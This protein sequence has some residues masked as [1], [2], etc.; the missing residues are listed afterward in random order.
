MMMLQE[1]YDFC[2]LVL[3]FKDQTILPDELV[4]LET[5]LSG[6]PEALDLYDR[7]VELYSG[8]YQSHGFPAS[9]DG[10]AVLNSDFW[11]C[12]ANEEITAPS[13]VI[14][15]PKQPSAPA[16]IRKVVYQ[17]PVRQVSKWSIFTL[18][19]SSAA[20]LLLSLFVRFAPAPDGREVATLTDSMN[21]R[22]SGG[23]ET[24]K[25]GVRL[26]AKS[27]SL[28][29][30]EGIAKLTFDNGSTVVVEGPA[31]F[32]ILAEDR[33]RVKYG[34][35]YTIVPRAVLGFSVITPN[36][37]II[38][39]GTEFG[40]IA[41]FDGSTE[42]HVIKGET[43]L[44]TGQ[45]E[46]KTSLLVKQGAAKQIYGESALVSDIVPNGRLFIQNLNSEANLIWRGGPLDLA[47]IVGGGNGFG[48]GKINGGFNPLKDTFEIFSEIVNPTLGPKKY[49]PVAGNPM[50]DGIFVPNGA[51]GP[52]QVSTQGHMFEK[53]P[54]TNGRFW[55]G[56]F[57]GAWHGAK[58]SNITRHSLRL[59]GKTYGTVQNASIYI[60]ANQGITFDLKAIRKSVGELNVTGFSARAG[61]SES[62]LDYPKLIIRNAAGQ[63]TSPLASF[64]VL[65]DGQV[66]F[67]KINVTP[68]D[69]AL[70]IDIPLTA[71]DQFLT[72]MAT[73]GSD[74]MEITHDWTLFAEP[75]L[76][77]ERQ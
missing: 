9:D 11:R 26:N 54:P 21:A 60:H 32:Q 47:D 55:Q 74:K 36:S 34:R 29:L 38:D 10:E 27:P 1:K 52:V 35:L 43:A 39:L 49:C 28:W 75:V 7:I 61:I 2:Q 33:L 72:L 48:T 30:N 4:R 3:K 51:N 76:H 70:S 69:T 18:I 23:K 20:L 41:G 5:M 66:R 17:K 13:A 45:H 77:I 16:L 12:L 19:A 8:L 22:W 58:A 63:I 50:I 68:E 67:E 62:V 25:S 42:L 59:G 65:V 40:V 64:Y 57:N 44:V 14:E 31:E 15:M 56:I 37:T 24:M 6:N 73:Q 71:N 46:K 53:C